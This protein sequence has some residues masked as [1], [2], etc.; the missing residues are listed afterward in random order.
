MNIRLAF[1]NKKRNAQYSVG[2]EIQATVVGIPGGKFLRVRVRGDEDVFA[3]IPS[4]FYPAAWKLTDTPSVSAGDKIRAKVFEYVEKDPKF[5]NPRLILNLRDCLPNDYNGLSTLIGSTVAVTIK[6]GNIE[7]GLIASMVDR[8]NVVGSIKPEEI[9]ID[10]WV[11]D[12]RYYATIIDVSES[13]QHIQFSM[14]QALEKHRQ[15]KRS[16]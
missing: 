1:Q 15:Q 13:R 3:M 16:A 5:G 14:R 9:T 7:E 2:S 4:R 10:F 12:Y 11:A 6:K 8:P